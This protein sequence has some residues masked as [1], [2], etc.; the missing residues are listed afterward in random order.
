MQQILI[1][2][3][4]GAV[5]GLAVGPRISCIGFIG[6][7]FLRLLRCCVVPLILCNIILAV[8]GMGDV[9]KL[10]RI[11]IK[12]IVIF[13]GTTILA[14]TVGLVTA[15]VINPGHGF[16]MTELGEV[17]EQTAP[18][19]SGIVLN[20]FGTN[21]IGSMAEGTMLHIISFAIISGIG[22]MYM[23][24]DDQ[25]KLLDG[26][27]L[28]SRYIMSFLRLVMK[29]TPV[30]VSCL[31]ANTTGQYG[32]D[33]LG[34]LGKFILTI[35]VGLLV[36]AF[37]IYG[38]LYAVGTRKNPF[39][40]WKSISP[41]WTTSFSTCS[42][43]ATMPVSMR[44]C[45]ENLHLRKE[46]SDLTIPLGANMNM[47]GNGLWY[48]GVAVF[49][50]EVV[51]INMSLGTMVIAI[52]TGVLMTLGSPGIPGGIIVATTI[53]LQTLGMPIEFVALLSGIFSIMDMGITTVNCVG[54]VVVA[55]VVSASEEARARK[56]EECV[57]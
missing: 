37:V 57:K 47:D 29:F 35:Y 15:L 1:G 40:F 50:A 31:M 56:T 25:T 43:A 21:I 9:K 8:A 36:H 53:F 17:A 45:E 42:T 14:A 52:L 54:S 20:F 44:V 33:V 34:P 5:V 51:G 39:K 12:L 27:G 49:V 2:L 10:G 11:G 16:A 7:I 41:V 28:I 19:F 4:L 30:G 22:I 24:E 55:S 32:T 18:T 26:L 23:K 38:G 3:I 13:L 46:V 6:T 48:G